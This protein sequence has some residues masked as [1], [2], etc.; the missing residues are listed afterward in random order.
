[1]TEKS[2]EARLTKRVEQMGGKVIRMRDCDP[3]TPDRIVVQPPQPIKIVHEDVTQE[4]RAAAYEL[5]CK[6]QALQRLFDRTWT[7]SATLA[8]APGLI[9]EAREALDVLQGLLG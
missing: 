5:L 7:S 9:A 1:M 6:A 4:E 3:R 2:I 8:T